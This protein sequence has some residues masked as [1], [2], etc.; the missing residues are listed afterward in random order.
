MHVGNGGAALLAT[1]AERIPKRVFRL[2][3]GALFGNG[4]ATLSAAP[5]SSPQHDGSA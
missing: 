1:P 3:S 2:N 4:D 5:Q